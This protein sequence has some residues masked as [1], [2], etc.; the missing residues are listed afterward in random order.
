[1]VRV[2][3]GNPAVVVS[4]AAVRDGASEC[5]VHFHT[6]IALAVRAHHFVM[7]SDLAVVAKRGFV[8][9]PYIVRQG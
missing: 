7:A 9:D 3:E 5:R 6:E 1:M 8:A 2:T 4:A